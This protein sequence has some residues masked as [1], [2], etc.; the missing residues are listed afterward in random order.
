MT[1]AVALLVYKQLAVAVARAS[2]R[3]TGREE[4]A[5]GSRSPSEATATDEAGEA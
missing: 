2:E 3:P 4:H 1:R 5:R